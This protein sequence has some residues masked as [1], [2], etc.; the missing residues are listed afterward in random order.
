M[1]SGLSLAVSLVVIVIRNTVVLIFPHQHML[2]VTSV[3]FVQYLISGS[4]TI[5]QTYPFLKFILHIEF[6]DNNDVIA[7]N[8]PAIINK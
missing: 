7:N 3:V 8:K 5:E 2:Q 6:N 1:S 4:S